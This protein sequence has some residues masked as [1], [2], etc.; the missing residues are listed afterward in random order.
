MSS[1]GQPLP[2]QRGNAPPLPVIQRKAKMSKQA[3]AT[4][5]AGI[6]SGPLM[7]PANTNGAKPNTPITGNK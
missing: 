2:G 6:S 1:F 7:V 5:A 4:T 3:P